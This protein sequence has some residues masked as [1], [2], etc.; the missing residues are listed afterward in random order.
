MKYPGLI[1]KDEGITHI[2]M[3]SYSNTEIGRFLAQKSRYKISHH[4]YGEFVTIENLWVWLRDA[5]HLDKIKRMNNRQLKQRLRTAEKV[6]IRNFKAIILDAHYI[7]LKQHPEMME[8]FVTSELPLDLY[9]KS[10]EWYERPS[11]ATYWLIPALE[12]LRRMLKQGE[13]DPAWIIPYVEVVDPIEG[14]YILT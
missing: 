14:F 11:Y 8:S 10:G 2:N 12:D 7:R 3:S 13:Y 1:V 5:E 9:Y 6:E 4:R